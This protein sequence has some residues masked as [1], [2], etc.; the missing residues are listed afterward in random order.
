MLL[1]F[2]RLVRILYHS[3]HPSILDLCL[4]FLRNTSTIYCDE[5]DGVTARGKDTCPQKHKPN[6]TICDPN[7][8]TVNRFAQC[9]SKDDHY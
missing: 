8:R 7:L 6:A 4:I 2:A 3:S 9:G 5:C 1:V